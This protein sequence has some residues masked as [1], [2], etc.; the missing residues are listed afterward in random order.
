MP[1]PDPVP[2]LVISYVFLWRHQ[3]DGGEEEGR[4]ARPCAVVMTM[5]DED[6]DRRVYVVPITHTPPDDDP[7]AVALPLKVKQRLGLD[8]QPSWIVKRELNWFVWPGYDL[9]PVRR[10]RPDVF[11]WGMLPVEIFEAVRSGIGRHRRD[12]TLKLTPRL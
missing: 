4:K 12:R 2:G 7:H 8:D 9:R 11:A 5:T 1:L 3:R 6:G 10:D